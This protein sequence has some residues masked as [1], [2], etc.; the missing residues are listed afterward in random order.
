M[1][2]STRRPIGNRTNSSDPDAVHVAP[3][4]PGR[5]R[6]LA[7]FHA[8]TIVAQGER[9]FAAAWLASTGKTVGDHRCA[10]V[11]SCTMKETFLPGNESH[12]GCQV[13]VFSFP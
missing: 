13:R 8:R 3:G 12:F 6:L 10:R 11:Q 1:K 5:M 7:P 4:A 2:A 9:R